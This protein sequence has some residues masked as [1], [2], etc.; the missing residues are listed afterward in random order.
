MEPV[1]FL[2][3]VRPDQAQPQGLRRQ[4][5]LRLAADL[6]RAAAARRLT[7]TSPTTTRSTR[8]PNAQNVETKFTR[9]VTAEVGAALHGRAALARRGR[10]REGH[11]RGRWSTTA[12]TST[13]R[14][15][16]QVRG[17]LDLG[18]ALPLRTLVA[19]AAQRGR[20]RQRRPQQHGRELLLR[21]LRQQLRRRQVGQA[22]SRVRFV[23]G[24]RDRRD[25]RRSTSC[26]R[27]CEWNLPPYVFESVG[28]P[29]LLSATGCGRRSSP[30]GCG[31][32]PATPRCARAYA[33]VGAQVDL[34]FSVLHWYD[35]TLSV[36][37][38]RRIPGLAARG[39]RVDDLAQDHVAAEGARGCKLDVLLHVG[40]RPAAGAQ[41]SSR[42][43]SISTATS[44]F[45]CASSSA[46]S[47]AAS[48]SPS[49][50]YVVNG[51]VLARVGIDVRELR[52]LRRRRSSRRS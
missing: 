50:S 20:R 21:R 37:L 39:H 6:R 44:S 22:L 41:A 32:I 47:R 18:F 14:L 46:S 10:R 23:A 43:S 31:P 42:R 26:A 35:M 12:T 40:R 19:L 38:R 4:A 25:Q 48:P 28:T 24:L 49:S 36:G 27:W 15:T 2:R 52:A 45:D 29:S 1:G 17:E 11:R 7:S 16:P 8:C 5:R 13:G 33:S 3:P 9:L 51:F 30:Q 34:R